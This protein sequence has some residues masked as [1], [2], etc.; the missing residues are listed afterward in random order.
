MT[1]ILIESNTTDHDFQLRCYVS[2]VMDHDTSVSKVMDNFQ[3]ILFYLFSIY[4]FQNSKHVNLQ[5]FE[6]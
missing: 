1:K 4:L 5:E 6:E 3:N 2:K